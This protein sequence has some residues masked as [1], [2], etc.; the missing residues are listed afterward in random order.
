MDSRIVRNIEPV[1]QI[2]SCR[3]WNYLKLEIS[4]TSNRISCI[5]WNIGLCV[6]VCVRSL[7]SLSFSSRDPPSFFF[8]IE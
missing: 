6:M 1:K 2:Y 8:L 4:V 3:L 7:V 5:I